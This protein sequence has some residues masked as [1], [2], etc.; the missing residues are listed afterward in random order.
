MKKILV[1][2]LLLAA[3][4]VGCSEPTKEMKSDYE[5]SEFIAVLESYPDY[6]D[7][8]ADFLK[9]TGKDFDPVIARKGSLTQEYQ[10]SR[11][12]QLESINF[13][14]QANV[15]REVP[16]GDGIWDIELKDSEVSN[17]GIWVIFDM[18]NKQV[19]KFFGLLHAQQKG[20]FDPLAQN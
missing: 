1:M 9:A 8:K 14:P 17:R 10:Q 11:I 6:A 13:H 12:D 16:I 3:F 5:L 2:T 15:Y 4:L 20:T 7:Y 19:L 18:N